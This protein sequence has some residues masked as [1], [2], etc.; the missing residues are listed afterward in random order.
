MGDLDRGDGQPG[1]EPLRIVEALVRLDKRQWVFPPER[2]VELDVGYLDRAAGDRLRPLVFLGEEQER[3]DLR[4][5]LLV[6]PGVG[7][8]AD[9]ASVV[10]VV[11]EGPQPL[12]VVVVP[13][14]SSEVE[15]RGGL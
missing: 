1:R 14:A 2:Q 12:S 15:Q 13:R 5:R 6:G 8:Q 3:L 11:L 4:E 7:E 10:R 9:L